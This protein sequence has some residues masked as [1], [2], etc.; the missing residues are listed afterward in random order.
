M[1]TVRHDWIDAVKGLGIIL[2]VISHCEINDDNLQQA[3]FYLTPGYV[4]MFFMLAGYNARKEPFLPALGKKFKRLIIPYF[5]YGTLAILI[6]QNITIEGVTGHSLSHDF[7]ALF[8]SRYSTYKLGAE[9]NTMMLPLYMAPVW[10]LTAMFIAYIW[11]YIYIQL[12][13]K[14]SKWSCISIYIALTLFFT[15]N[16][17]LLPWSLDTSFLCS[18]LIISGYE[19]KDYFM[20]N[21]KKEIKYFAVFVI[22]CALYIFIVSINGTTNLSIKKY[23]NSPYTGVALF[24]MLSILIT[25]I[26]G[27]LFKSFTHTSI[28]KCFAFVGRQSLR[29]MCFHVPIIFLIGISTDMSASGIFVV[30]LLLS[31]L[32]SWIAGHLFKLASKIMP[33]FKYL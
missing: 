3:M 25:Y 18:L 13:S 21:N 30:S 7:S 15:D 24:F 31:I 4:S 11:F 19:F 2:I 14:A 17:L 16:D 23:G 32:M 8:Y 6:F 26:Y 29:I 33:F 5:V 27:E 1:A 22:A 12:K 10:F 9:G 20:A 28:T